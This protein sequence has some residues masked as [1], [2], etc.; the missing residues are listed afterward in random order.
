[1]FCESR[2]QGRASSSSRAFQIRPRSAVR[3][4]GHHMIGCLYGALPRVRL[5]DKV[6]NIE[7]APFAH[8]DGGMTF[9][10][11][12][13]SSKQVALRARGVF[14]SFLSFQLRR[15][16]APSRLDG[17]FQHCV[18]D[19]RKQNIGAAKA[20]PASGNRHK[21]RRRRLHEH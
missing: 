15:H 3:A 17:T 10:T 20:P 6:F 13:G 18:F 2:R 21:G 7:F 12:A 9:A 11:I 8:T 19:K 14:S 4:P 16:V 5:L 1:M